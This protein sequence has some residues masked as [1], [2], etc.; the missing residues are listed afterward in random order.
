MPMTSEG[1][2]W[3]RVQNGV[4]IPVLDTPE[5]SAAINAG[6]PDYYGT[7]EGAILYGG[8]QATAFERKTVQLYD[9]RAWLEKGERIPAGEKTTT[10]ITAKPPTHK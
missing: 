2:L 7:I 3:F 8:V 5:I 1:F 6:A 10:T 4:A 9:S